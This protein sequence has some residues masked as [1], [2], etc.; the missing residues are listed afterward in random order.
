MSPSILQE[1]TESGEQTLLSQ[2]VDELVI[3]EL[4]GAALRCNYGQT[5][6]TMH[7]FVSA[8]GLAGFDGDLFAVRNGN[9]QVAKR[10]IEESGAKV[11]LV[12][13]R[14]KENMRN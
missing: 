6:G 10:C 8:V 2:G 14:T 13:V 1:I 4:G 12:G 5:A 11:Y 9:S 7:G 3:E